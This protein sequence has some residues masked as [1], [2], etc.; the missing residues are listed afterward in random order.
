MPSCQKIHLFGNKFLWNTKLYSFYNY[1]TWSLQKTEKKS[2]VKNLWSYHPVLPTTLALKLCSH[3]SGVYKW[4]EIITFW[5]TFGSVYVRLYF[6]KKPNSLTLHKFQLTFFCDRFPHT[7]W[8]PCHR[9]PF[10]NKRVN[11]WGG[12]PQ[13]EMKALIMWT[14]PRKAAPSLSWIL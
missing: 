9:V 10:S 8:I 1:C 4:W 5:W 2:K 12:Q 14:K 11:P 7:N 13:L 3:P 6:L